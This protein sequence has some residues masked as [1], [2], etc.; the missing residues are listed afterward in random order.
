MKIL[1]A[2][3]GSPFSQAAI[4]KV[5]E[6]LPNTAETK[7]KMLGVYEKLSPVT[8]DPFGASL[9]YYVEAENAARK[10]S[11]DAVTEAADLLKSRFPETMFAVSTD[12]QCGRTARVIVD[13]AAEWPADLIVV[14]SH[15]YGF[16]ERNLLGSV[17]NSVVHHAACSVLVVRMPAV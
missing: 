13:A 15:G 4:E 5:A 6:I 11:E 16:W 7:V 1:I 2:T 17:S 9:Q 10:L 8:G 3:D 12:V 14:G